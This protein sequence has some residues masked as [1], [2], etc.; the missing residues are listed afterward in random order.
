VLGS[1]SSGNCTFVAAGRARILVDA[2]FSCREI[3]KRLVGI[4]ERTD[5]IQGIL[6]THE[7][8]D[9]IGGLAR[10]AKKHRIPVYISART[11]AAL[12]P[13]TD[14]TA[15]ETIEPGKPFVIEDLN[16]EPFSIP[17]DAVDPIA[18]RLSAEGLCVAVATD[19]G[20]LPENVKYHLRGCHLMVIESNHDIEMLRNGPYPW[21]VKER[22]WSRTGHLSNKGLGDFLRQDYDGAAQ[23]VVLA[24]L[25]EQNN[26]PQIARMEATAAL[27]AVAARG[28][29]CPQLVVSHQDQA[30]PVFEF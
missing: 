30:T 29:G 18:F 4:G 26:H 11:R 7:H 22:V 9:H 10:L 1:G 19:L 21:Y 12:P 3:T 27:E 6:I 5:S 28:N 14:L 20:Y 17:H 15:V 16:V 24:H 23:V 8:S 25:S 13:N 2:G